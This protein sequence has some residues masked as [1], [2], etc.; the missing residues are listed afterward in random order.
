MRKACLLTDNAKTDFESFFNSTH[1]NTQSFKTPTP[2][3]DGKSMSSQTPRYLHS[4][5]SLICTTF[6]D[7]YT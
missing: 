4:L 6:E 1:T 5:C 2:M 3:N 7:H